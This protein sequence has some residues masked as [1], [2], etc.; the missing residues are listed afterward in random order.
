MSSATV[1]ASVELGVPSRRA[2]RALREFDQTAELMSAHLTHRYGEAEAAALVADA[3]ARLV[4]MLP[5]VS[6]VEGRSAAAMNSFLRITAEEIA[7]YQAVVARGGTAAGAWELCHRG[8]RLAASRVPAWKKRLMNRILFSG[9][10]R[11]IIK[12]RAAQAEPLR[13][14]DFVTRSVVGDG[15]AFDFGVDYVRCGNLELARQEGAEAFAPYICMS[16]IALSEAFGWGLVRTQTLADGCS[17]C[18]FRFKRGGDTRIT[19]PTQRVQETIDRI[20]DEEAGGRRAPALHP[21]VAVLQRFDPK[22]VAETLDVFAE[23]VVWRFF[24]PRLPNLQGDYVGR[25]GVERFFD[26][27]TKMTR[28]TF[29]VH[30]IRLTP[31]GD[32]LLV[33]QNRNTMRIGKADIDIDVVVVWRVV[34]GEIVEVWDIPSVRSARGARPRIEMEDSRGARH[35]VRARV[36]GSS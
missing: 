8:L 12:R 13:R 24:N 16:D 18:D 5:R 21:N 14:G 23:D 28:G 19:T 22:R 15:N 2:N 4:A 33:S 17:H 3:R 27:V 20:A 6:W 25:S 34:D 10:V 36:A 29:A 26:K 35:R 7:V 9:P 31:V 11:S 32:E 1:K 30:P